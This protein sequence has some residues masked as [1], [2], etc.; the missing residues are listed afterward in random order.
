MAKSHHYCNGSYGNPVNRALKSSSC[1]MHLSYMG[2]YTYPWEYGQALW[3]SQLLSELPPKQERRGH[4]FS[5][6]ST[7]TATSVSHHYIPYGY[8]MVR[9]SLGMISLLTV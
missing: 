5:K 3:L 9:K 6:A 8:H 4:P 7:I 2:C 1:L